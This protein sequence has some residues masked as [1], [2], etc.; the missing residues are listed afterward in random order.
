MS[1]KVNFLLCAPLFLL[2]LSCG[3]AESYKTPMVALADVVQS[4][5]KAVDKAA[6]LEE[7]YDVKAENG[8]ISLLHSNILAPRNSTMGIVDRD[9]NLS[10][11]GKYN[12][13]YLEAGELF[14]SL[15]E[16]FRYSSAETNCYYDLAIR[17]TNVS[18]G[19]YDFML[20]D[21]DGKLVYSKEVK[22]R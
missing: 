13:F 7:S 22:V 14:I 9:G 20:F 19:I 1:K 2:F 21:N 6:N 15:Q 3:G 8:D 4:E 18:G 16:K 11:E 10:Y 17:I 5:C 12:Y